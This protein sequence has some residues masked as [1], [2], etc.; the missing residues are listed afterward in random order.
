MPHNEPIL[1][2]STE[3]WRF[4][5][6][7]INAGQG[8]IESMF[9]SI[10]QRLEGSWATDVN[11]DFRTWGD[12][13]NVQLVS[14]VDDVL[15]GHNIWLTHT[16]PHEAPQTP[17][18]PGAPLPITPITFP[19]VIP[20]PVGLPSLPNQNILNPGGSGLV[21]VIQEL[22]KRVA[23][24][25]GLAGGWRAAL[26]TLLATLG[27]SQIVDIVDQWIP[28][29]GDDQQQQVSLVLEAFA[30]LEDAGL[31]RPWNPRARRDGQPA[32]G[33]YY[34]IFDLTQMMGN[35]SNFHMS[36]KGLATHDDKKDTL[37]RPA[38]ARRRN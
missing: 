31:I 1:I 14:S 27:V 16:A 6:G 30:N 38:R 2:F 7:R 4:L 20:P 37:K 22:M 5:I 26:N 9:E 10:D 19:P 33:P 32:P 21:R 12:N 3:Q 13:P 17:G 8:N 24:G 11:P 15:P 29:L 35:Y 34:M 23:G 25:V 28:G 18:V 36:R